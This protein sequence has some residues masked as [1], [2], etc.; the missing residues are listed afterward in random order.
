MERLAFLPVA[1]VSTLVAVRLDLSYVGLAILVGI[2]I[3]IVFMVRGRDMFS[4]TAPGYAFAI[5]GLGLLAIAYFVCSHY[6][7]SFETLN[8]DRSFPRVVRRLPYFA[9]AFL[10]SGATAIVISGFLQGKQRTT[11]E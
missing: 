1:I 10:T 5:V 4:S 6:G 11:P 8:Q 9:I 2:G 7:I 3:P